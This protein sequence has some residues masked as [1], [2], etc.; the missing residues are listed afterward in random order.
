MSS[1]QTQP[2]GGR[3]DE[4]AT[5][6]LEPY[7]GI[8]LLSFGGPEGHDEV[9]PFLQR[10]TAGRGIPDERLAEVAEHYHS[11]GGISPINDQ[12]RALVAALETEL[13]TRGLDLPVRL[14]NRN[15]A[16][17][18]VDTLAQLHAAGVRRL[19]T[20]LTSAYSSY[21]SCRQYR[22]NLADAVAEL[23]PGVGDTLVI[24]KVEPW[25]GLPG[26]VE[27]FARGI[28]QA[29][30][31]TPLDPATVRVLHVTHSIPD[32]MAEA[33]GPPE[34]RGL[35]VDQHER[36]AAVIDAL[37]AETLG[38]SVDSELV[39]CS[40]SGPPRQPWLEP[41]V[42]DRIT[43]LAAEGVQRVVVVPMGFVSDH[44]EVISDLDDD[45]VDAGRAAGVE[46]IRVA[47]P[48]T[49]PALVRDL[50]DLMVD[51]A[52]QARGQSER[53][54]GWLVAGDRRPSTCVADCCPNLRG[55]RASLC[56]AESA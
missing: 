21:S 44:M 53:T 51:R 9:L 4:A 42:A 29:L 1:P 11:R 13:A 5:S 24:D 34:L 7:D 20:V 17:F 3:P 55:P 14:G 56:G 6:S 8:L 52:A 41:D 28:S 43:A 39:Y 16:P 38:Q 35:Y 50:V 48:G 22:E 12:N 54:A 37:V 31:S 36:V 32:A 27:T 30:G 18:L 46:V 47:T 10:V 23:G 19:L 45:A 25:H 40:R 49:D 2:V 26:F 15:S 33:S